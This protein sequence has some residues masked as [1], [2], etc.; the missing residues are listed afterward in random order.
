MVSLSVLYF[1]GPPTQEGTERVLGDACFSF[2]P[3]EV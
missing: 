1:G 3:R 2:S